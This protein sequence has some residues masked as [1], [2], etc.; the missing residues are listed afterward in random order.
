[1]HAISCVFT[2]AIISLVFIARYNVFG[3]SF[4]EDSFDFERRDAVADSIFNGEHL[5]M[6]VATDSQVAELEKLIPVCLAL[7]D[8]MLQ[9]LLEE[10]FKVEPTLL[11][12]RKRYADYMRRFENTMDD[13]FQGYFNA[14]RRVS[15]A[16]KKTL[17]DD[18]NKFLAK[19][20]PSDRST[21]SK[22]VEAAV[23]GGGA[24]ESHYMALI[25]KFTEACPTAN[26]ARRLLALRRFLEN[27]LMN[28]NN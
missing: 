1:M 19:L 12:R 27:E 2:F 8:A 18:L 20:S 26:K 22:H 15:D 21:M 4:Y 3:A 14:Q 25:V 28:D 16:D 10:F 5:L 23:K 13:D 24:A 17:A 9:K 11:G 7:P 6:N